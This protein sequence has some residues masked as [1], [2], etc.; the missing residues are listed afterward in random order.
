MRTS[1]GSQRF[2]I[3]LGLLALVLAGCAP[4]LPAASAAVLPT[5]AAAIA[6]PAP[7]PV[8][9]LPD[10]AAAANALEAQIIAVY[11]TVGPT[12]VNI[13]ARGYAYDRFMRA[14]PQEGTGSGFVYD[15]AGHIITNYHVVENATDLLVTL[16]SGKVYEAEI[17]GTDAVNDLAVLHIDA[18]ADLPIPVALG[19]S[20]QL[21]V[22]QFVLAIGNPFGLEQTL[23]TG[24]VSALGRVIESPD[25]N[26][27]ISEV[28]QTDAA[29]NPGNSGGPLLDLQGRVIGVNS[30][31]MSTSGSS[32]GIG[33]AVSVNTVRRVVPVLIATGSYPHP[34]LDIQTLDLTPS[35]VEVLRQAGMNVPVDAGLMV[36]EAGAGG[37]AARAGVQGTGR[38][39]R[40]GHYRV[41][42][43]G[44]IIVAV[45]GKPTASL[46]ELMVYLESQ[47]T[48]GDIVELTVVRG[49]VERTIQ[50]TLADQSN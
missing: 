37:P 46:Q 6:T 21:R 12:V 41:P 8:A 19:D 11:E 43:D 13:T 45:D 33:F 40:I 23:T 3:M 18:G 29:I 49:G 26:G 28:I 14:V 32:A 20:D 38:W 1:F 35:T 4:N 2:V 44:D 48:V 5:A 22:G 15:T 39:V 47:T 31:I 36:I 10:E 30:Q 9:A 42:V 24:V 25:D 27:F 16:A 50:V 17:V 7:A 34:S